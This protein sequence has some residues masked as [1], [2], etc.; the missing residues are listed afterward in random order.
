M[1]LPNSRLLMSSTLRRLSF[2]Y[3]GVIFVLK[4]LYVIAPIIL[5]CNTFNWFKVV[6][7]TPPQGARMF[8]TMS[9]S[10]KLR[11]KHFSKGGEKF[12]CAPYLRACLLGGQL[13]PSPYT[14]SARQ[15]HFSHLSQKFFAQRK[16]MTFNRRLKTLAPVVF[17]VYCL[18]S[19]NLIQNFA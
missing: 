4:E 3:S 5:L 16:E 2:L 11:P 1:I 8:Q 6:M 7:P 10:F 18:S 9:N 13:C 17:G 15:S 12:S 14:F 19:Q